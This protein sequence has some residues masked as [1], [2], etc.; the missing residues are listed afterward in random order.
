MKRYDGDGPGDGSFAGV[1]RSSGL[2]RVRMVRA[3][4]GALV[5]TTFLVAPTGN[6]ASGVFPGP[7]PPAKCGS[8]SLPEKQQGRVPQAD[9]VS[10][11]ATKGYTCNAFLVSHIP[12]NGAYKVQR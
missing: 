6:T 2:R 3:A 12:G 5:A 11:R 1:P 7:V 4:V 10:G 9:V 8:G